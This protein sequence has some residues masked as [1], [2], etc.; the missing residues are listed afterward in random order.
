MRDLTRAWSRLKGALVCDECYLLA[1][2][3][4]HARSGLWARVQYWWRRWTAPRSEVRRL[5]AHVAKLERALDL[6]QRQLAHQMEIS[7]QPK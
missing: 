4:E 2:D 7:R 6:T 1:E 3:C 5:Q